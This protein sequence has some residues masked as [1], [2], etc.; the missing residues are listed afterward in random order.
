M[1]YMGFDFYVSNQLTSTAT[2]ELA[3]DVTGNDTVTIA[4]QVFKFV[5]SIGTAAGEVLAGA[6]AAATRVNLAALINAP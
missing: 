6:N 4:G 5:A 2:L 1:T 3:N